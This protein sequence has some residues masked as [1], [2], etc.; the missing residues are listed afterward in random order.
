M[1]R[2]TLIDKTIKSISKLPDDRLKE[3]SDY[4]EF[5]LK[6]YEDEL[7][8]EG[9]NRLVTESK[10]YKFLDEEEELYS[11]SDLKEVYHEKR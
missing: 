4:A 8:Q 7:I 2:T 6:K 5:I 10:A 11:V 9:I 1:L 3:V